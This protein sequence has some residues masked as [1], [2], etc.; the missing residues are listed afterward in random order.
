MDRSHLLTEQRLPQSMKLDAMSVRDAVEL[1][2]AQDAIAVAAVATQRETI[3]QGV[4]LVAG[5]AAQGGDCSISAQAPAADWGFWMLPNA[6]LLS[7]STR[8][9]CRPSLPEDRPPC[10]RRWREPKTKPGTD[11]QKWTCM[12]LAL[13]TWC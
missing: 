9:K 12:I 6:R 7:G 3:A 2:S 4:E 11:R 10:F 13:P 8:K 1:M 5:A